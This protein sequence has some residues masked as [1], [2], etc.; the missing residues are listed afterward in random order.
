MEIINSAPNKKI[1]LSFKLT[2]F[3]NIMDT[4]DHQISQHVR[5]VASIQLGSDSLKFTC[6][7]IFLYDG[8]PWIIRTFKQERLETQY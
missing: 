5:I 7:H 4:W 6:L 8:L 1:F 3:E 2:L